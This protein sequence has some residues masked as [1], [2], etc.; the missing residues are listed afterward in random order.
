ML[1]SSRRSDSR[2][3]K[4]KYDEEKKN[5]GELF[6]LLVFP[7]YDLTFSP[8]SEHCALL[9]ECLELPTSKVMQLKIKKKSKFG[10]GGGGGGDELKVGGAFSL[11][12]RWG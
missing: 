11:F 9:S 12:K 8:P 2:A 4:K 5:G 3:G 1:A 6:F 7:A 10:F